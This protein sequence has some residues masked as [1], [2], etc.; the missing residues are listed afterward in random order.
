M[1]FKKS[2]D[3]YVIFP[4][5]I[6]KPWGAQ[7]A[8]GLVPFP[9]QDKHFD[10]IPA[11]NRLMLSRQFYDYFSDYEWIL[12]HHLDALWLAPDLSAFLAKPY[13]YWGAP[14]D[15]N[16]QVGRYYFRGC[17]MLKNYFPSI[18]S[19]TG[20]QVGNGGYCLRRIAPTIR[21]LEKFPFTA[22]TWN[23]NEDYFF[24][25]MGVERD[26]GY[27]IAPRAE[28]AHFSKEHGLPDLLNSDPSQWPAGIHGI[29]NLNPAALQFLSERSIR[30][31]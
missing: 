29:Q 1:E 7:E 15:S 12:I 14:W 16:P 6:K 24:A 27:K 9:L 3:T 11:Y 22:S 25:R 13:D 28:A 4:E 8:K 31:T 21:L 26:C 10:G 17:G 19:E 20:C 30:A 18:F 23:N 5:S 2:Y